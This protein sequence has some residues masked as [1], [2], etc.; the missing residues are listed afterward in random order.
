MMKIY[1]K[2]AFVFLLSMVSIF[3]FSQRP[4][5]GGFSEAGGKIMGQLQDSES[6]TPLE[7]AAISVLQASDSTLISGGISDVEGKFD[8]TV[9]PGKYILK[10]EYISF[11]TRWVDQTTLKPGS[12]PV[13]LGVIILE[14][15]A[16]TLEEIEVIAEKSTLQMGLDK[17]IF[18]VGKDLANRGGNAADILDNIPSVT[19][20]IEGEVSLRGSTGVRILVDGK[21]SGLIGI[22]NTKGLQSLQGNMI[23]RVEIITNPSAKYEAEGMSGIINII[24]KKNQQKGFNGTFDASIG[25]PELFG[26]GSNVNYRKSNVNIFAQYGYRRDGSPGGGSLLQEIFGDNGSHFVDQIQERIRARESHTFRGGLDLFINDKNIITASGMYRFS[27]SDNNATTTYNDLNEAR[28]LES[29]TQRKEIAVE[30]E[31]NTEWSLDYKKTFDKKGRKF[32]IGL[33]YRDG[34]EDQFSDYTEIDY[35]SDFTPMS[36]E[37]LIQRSNNSEGEKSVTATIDYVEPIGK[38]GKFETGYRGSFGDINNKYLVEE[39]ID[40]DW[41]RLDNQSNNFIYNEDIH[42]FYAT[43]G[44]KFG[45]FSLQGGLRWEYSDITTLLKDTDELNDR[46]YNNFFPSAFVGYDLPNQNTIQASYSRRLRRPRFRYLNPFFSFADSRNIFSG[47]PNLDPEFTDSYEMG[48]I[49]YWDKSSI[50]SSIY[51]RHT[52]NEI[53]RILR[54]DDEGISYRRPEN[55]TSSNSVGIEFTFNSAF[56]KWWDINGSANFYRKVTDGSNLPVPVE[57]TATSMTTRLTNKWKVGKKIEIQSRFNYRAPQASPQGNRKS[58]IHADYAMSLDVLK[59]KGTLNF[60]ISDLFNSRKWRYSYLS[61]TARQD[62]EFQWRSRQ[63]TL[64]MN[65]RI[66]QKKKRGGRGERGG[67]FE[68]GGEEGF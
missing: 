29:I 22:G 11:I 68:G 65:Y 46:N 33:R 12:G 51:Y 49:K 14:P 59:G 37:V 48:H 3:A 36:D 57:A 64:S 44:N 34:S 38:D 31:P 13:N 45:K 6:G 62:G 47:N 15:N 20:D 10:I 9:K 1:I 67:G 54:Y 16:Q 56:S 66:N 25:H 58:M 23:E 53:E 7:F 4:S 42:A 5:G 24:L 21:P 63:Y 50:S 61:E 19:V 17:K 28:V 32:D 41:S 26:I 2:N 27:K 55:L 35:F 40:N 43:L 60:S 8:I 30:D 39:Q 52:T 18:N